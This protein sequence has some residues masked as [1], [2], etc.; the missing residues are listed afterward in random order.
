MEENDFKLLPI[1]EI[2]QADYPYGRYLLDTKT[3]Q[4]TYDHLI[5]DE[6]FIRLM[7]TAL[8]RLE[9]TYGVPVQFEFAIEIIDA[10]GGPDYKLYILQCHTA[11]QP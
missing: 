6:K 4:L 1:T 5:E 10:P 7:R 3:D 11:A 9:N 2:L 8:T